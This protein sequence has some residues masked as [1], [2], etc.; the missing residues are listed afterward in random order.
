MTSEKSVN[1]RDVASGRLRGSGALV[2]TGLLGA[3]ALLFVGSAL[4]RSGAGQYMP[5]IVGIPTVLLLLMTFIADLADFRAQRRGVEAGPAPVRSD[6]VIAEA[7]EEF[8]IM[9]DDEH[10]LTERQILLWFVFLF[11]A[12]WFLGL[13][14]AGILF[15]F[16]FMR[17]AGRESL[18]LSLAVSL[19]TLG[20][21]HFFFAELL[22]A[23]LYRG[24]V[25][26]EL[27]P[28]LAGS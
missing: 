14:P 12:F 8:G 23:Q 18:G 27:I 20:I 9:Q 19:G 5:L 22:G 15:I 21:I 1:T 16:F 4:G 11:A 7:Q 25:T 13:V 2:L 6:E 24:Y 26:R 17:K 10:A 28:L 3:M